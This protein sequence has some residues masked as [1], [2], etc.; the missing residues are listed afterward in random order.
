VKFYRKF[1]PVLLILVVALTLAACDTGGSNNTSST[2]NT[3][4]NTTA[5]S[6][7]SGSSAAAAPTNTAASN[8]ATGATAVPPTATYPMGDSNPGAT[9]TI[10]LWIMPNTGNS[11]DDMIALLTGFKQQFPNIN[12][13]VTVLDWGS[14]FTKITNAVTS[15]EGPDVTQLGTTWVGAVS[16]LD[17]LRPYTAD[18]ITSMGGQASFFPAAW[19]TSHQFNTTAITAIPWFLDVRALYYRSDI[20]KNLNIDPATGLD[21][22]DHFDAT[23]AKVKAANV[24]TTTYVFPGK[25]DWNVVHNFAPWVWGAGGD[26]L[27]PDNSASAFNSD[28]ALAGVKEYTSFVTKGYTPVSVLEKNTADAENIFKSGGA[29]FVVAGSWIIGQSR[30][31]SA[32]GGFSDMAA[33]GK[34]GVVPIPAGPAGSLTFVGGSD[35]SV[36]KSSQHPTEAVALVKYLVSQQAN[37]A[38]AKLSGNMPASQAGYGDP[39]FSGDPMYQVFIKAASTGKSYP[40]I[41]AWGAIE[42]AMQKNLSGL[43]DDV[44]GVNGPFQDSMVK[45]RLDQAAAEVN[46]AIAANK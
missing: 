5:A 32:N 11:K 8:A 34:F 9:T 28:K 42:S 43:W 6:P 39:Y 2:N 16:A 37:V 22:W 4:S 18:E 36:M 14:A 24:V 27:T 33:A 23:M 3:A 44:A 40:T 38:Y 31:T 46:A 15:G 1:S 13:Q 29:A 21:T 45:A 30:Q 20:L 26:M 35:L 17:G 19:N 10:K 12:V 7:T 25:N 41:A